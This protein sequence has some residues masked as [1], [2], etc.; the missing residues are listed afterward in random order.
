MPIATYPGTRSASAAATTAT[1]TGPRRGLRQAS[2][3]WHVVA[4]VAPAFVLI[5]ALYLLPNALNLIVAFT[6]YSSYKPR[7]NWVGL[8][9]FRELAAAGYFW[10]PLWITLQYAA[11]VAVLQNIGALSLALAL[12]RNVRSSRILR[13]ILFLPVLI[14]PLAAGYIWVGLLAP[15]GIVN[16]AISILTFRSFHYPW[17]GS[18]TAALPVLACIQAWRWGGLT[19]IIYIAGLTS[20]P[21]DLIESAQVEG[22]SYWE[23]F[24]RI[25]FPLLAPALTFNLTVTVIGGLSA[26]DV[27][28]ATT[29]G[30]PGNATELLN[31]Q[32][33]QEFGNGYIAAASALSMTL[34][35][36]VSLLAIPLIIR[37]RRREVQL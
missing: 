30:G 35:V 32:V 2:A 18:F 17:F 11:M 13:T 31:L 4:F 25:K 9:N 36:V 5:I 3:H 14:S 24:R 34:F 10:H 21:P 27:I 23:V 22:A 6:G 20:I 29:M 8:T 7:L 15:N 26:F 28:F 16:G 12:E 19:M 37:L 33:W 1:Q